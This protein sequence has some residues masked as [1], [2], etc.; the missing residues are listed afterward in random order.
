[1][2][3]NVLVNEKNLLDEKKIV[4]GL[5]KV[6]YFTNEKVGLAIRN[7]Y[8]L[9]KPLF[10]EGP[11]GVGKTQ[12]AKSLKK[13]ME[14]NWF[15]LQCTPEMNEKKALYEMNYQK[16]LLCIQWYK[17][18]DGDVSEKK[19]DDFFFTRDFLIERPL[20]QSLQQDTPSVLLVD[21]I[22]KSEE[23]FEYS[24]L[25]IFGE[26]SVTISEI[27]ETIFA[28]EIPFTIVTSNDARP[29]SDT[30]LRRCVYL[31]LDYPT[32]EEEI[33]II[34]SILKVNKV[35]AKGVAKALKN[36]REANDIKLKQTPSI[37]EGIEW[38]QVISLHLQNEEP[39]NEEYHV[40][41]KNEMLK[42]INVIA[43]SK[44]DSKKMYKKIEAM[45][46]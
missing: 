17:N 1:M 35:I 8:I 18:K 23:E 2:N 36:I 24:L 10:V 38:A 41:L 5:S 15:R 6:G 7:A 13:M 28:K 39:E 27:K 43:K 32:L 3:A 19:L 25:E 21:E 40:A 30:M 42:N 29:I 9:K 20:L 16:Q 14:W 26:Y 11:P 4:E 37:S 31:Y 12:L 33:N 44:E 46:V 45:T 34:K 22:D